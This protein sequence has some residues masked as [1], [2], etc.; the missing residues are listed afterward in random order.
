MINMVMQLFHKVQ[1]PGPL[2][3]SLVLVEV[4]FLIYLKI[5]LEWAVNKVED[6]LPLD[7]ILD[8]IYLFPLNKHFLETK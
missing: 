7:L 6:Q 3:V 1:V 2:E 4:D 5:C 8:M